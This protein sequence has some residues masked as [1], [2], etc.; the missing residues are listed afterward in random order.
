MLCRITW[1]DRVAPKGIEAAISHKELAIV[2][3]KKTSNKS[4]N[5][6][7]F[8]KVNPIERSHIIKNKIGEQQN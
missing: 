5:R 2:T 8:S 3:K 7:Q 1:A 6:K 4:T